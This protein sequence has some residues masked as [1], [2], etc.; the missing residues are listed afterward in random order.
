MKFKLVESQELQETIQLNESTYGLDKKYTYHNLLQT[1]L[2]DRV[3][4]RLLSDEELLPG[5]TVHSNRGGSG[6]QKMLGT[7][8]VLHHIGLQHGAL[9]QVK[10]LENADK[11]NKIHS[12]LFKVVHDCL[13]DHENIFVE[14]YKIYEERYNTANDMFLAAAKSGSDEIY[15]AIGLKFKAYEDYFR[16]VQ[17]SLR[18][19][20]NLEILRTA[21]LDAIN[22]FN[23]DNNLTTN[24][25][26]AE[27]KEI[28]YA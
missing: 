11:H 17:K 2:S 16:D 8:S 24:T 6:I 13:K 15:T 12:E 22:Q 5:F 25:T 1:T 18:S 21:V 26:E 20:T 9:T 19:N 7:S 23:I 10:E 28:I 3:L 14:C 27:A 4:F